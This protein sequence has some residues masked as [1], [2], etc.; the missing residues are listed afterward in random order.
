MQGTRCRHH[1]QQRRRE[2]EIEIV[3]QCSELELKTSHSN[4]RTDMNRLLLPH[5]SSSA[6]TGVSVNRRLV[7]G[8]RR[9]CT[10]WWD[11]DGVGVVGV[12]VFLLVVKV[13]D[14]LGCRT[15]FGV[16]RGCDE[17]DDCTV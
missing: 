14:R 13:D 17:H 10:R 1:E 2:R 9:W 12:R 16:V 5:N 4:T 11:A 7:V 8:N 3:N 15:V 6:N